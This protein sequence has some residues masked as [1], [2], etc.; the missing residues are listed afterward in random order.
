MLKENFDF[1]L[2]QTISYNFYQK[3]FVWKNWSMVNWNMEVSDG[4]TYVEDEIF[5]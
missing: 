4:Q 2:T 1:D 3:E 5:V